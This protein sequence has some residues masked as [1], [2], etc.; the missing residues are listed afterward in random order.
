[1]YLHSLYY[2]MT[3][4]LPTNDKVT[5]PIT[6]P[7][8]STFTFY[9]SKHVQVIAKIKYDTLSVYGDLKGLIFLERNKLRCKHN[10]H[11][12]INKDNAK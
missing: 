2:S 12:T 10:K 5:S 3:R 6:R 4:Y 8:T 9:D 1:M 11:N 7:R